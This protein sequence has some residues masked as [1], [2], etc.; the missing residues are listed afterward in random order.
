[1]LTV[2]T[3]PERVRH[4]LD[5]MER[6]PG[7]GSSIFLFADREALQTGNPL[8]HLFVNGRGETTRLID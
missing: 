2:T 7:G 6:L 8:T 4:L 5:A 1:V 3:S